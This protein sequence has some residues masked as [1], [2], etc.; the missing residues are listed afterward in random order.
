MP[1]SK[2]NR[3]GLI[4]LLL[5]GVVIVYSPRIFSALNESKGFSISYEKSKELEEEIIS[6]KKSES[7]KKYKK[8]VNKYSAP[9]KSFNPNEYILNDWVKL[10]LSKKQA[11]VILKFTARKIYSN[12]ELEKIFVLPKE[13]FNL[14]KDSTFYPLRNDTEIYFQKETLIVDLNNSSQEELETIPGIGAFFASEIIEYRESLGGFI[15][16]KQMLEI[17]KFDAEKLRAIQPYIKISNE[18][19]KQLNIN[20]A[21]IDELKNHPYISYS[22]ANSIV[23]MRNQRSNYFNIEEI[24]ESKLIDEEL[25]N[26]IKPY[27]KVL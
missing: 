4:W 25:F 7:K 14:L 18:N 15:N 16:Y 1:I 13:L 21:T 20:S 8:K 11:E 23:K 27:L 6:T 3:R 5:I 17:W 22:V 12:K 26:K 10:G 9:S 24:K 19:F 2:R